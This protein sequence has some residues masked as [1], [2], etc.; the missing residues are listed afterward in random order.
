M[1]QLTIARLTVNAS[2]AQTS[3]ELE[4]KK[5][6]PTT[7]TQALSQEWKTLQNNYEQYEKSALLIKLTGVV[8]YAIELTLALNALLVSAIV[9][10][11]WLQESIFRTYQSRL[12]TRIFRIEGLLKQGAPAEGSA[13]QLHSEWIANRK[14][15]AGLIGEYAANAT[16]PTVAFPYVAL[17]LIEVAIYLIAPK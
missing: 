11:L 12:G 9:V 14:G 5:I 4:R 10:I 15:I 13:F 2:I 16:K 17:L 7:E 6:M 1:E 8:L 3:Y